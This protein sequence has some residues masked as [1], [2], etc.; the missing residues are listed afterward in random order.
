VDLSYGGRFSELEPL[1][2]CVCRVS[3]CLEQPCQEQAIS[4][5]IWSLFD[6]MP[7][8]SG[9]PFQTVRHE[10]TKRLLAQVAK[11]VWVGLVGLDC[12]PKDLQPLLDLTK[13]YPSYP[14][15]SLSLSE[16][17]ISIESRLGVVFGRFEIPAEIIVHKARDE[18]SEVTVGS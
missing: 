12:A 15:Q 9:R 4:V 11:S 10:M 17:G 2:S 14:Q 8:D 5:K 13:M 1:R 16:G 18:V 6:K 7:R 3:R